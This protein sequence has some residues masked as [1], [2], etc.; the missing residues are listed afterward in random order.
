[1]WTF[2][3]LAIRT[4]VHVSLLSEYTT[5]YQSTYSWRMCTS[6]HVHAVALVDCPFPCRYIGIWKRL[7]GECAVLVS[8]S[9]Y[10][11][12]VYILSLILLI[13]YF[14]YRGYQNVLMESFSPNQVKTTSKRRRKLYSLR[15]VVHRSSMLF[16]KFQNAED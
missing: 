12:C 6:F 11:L 1:M 8:V 3:C 14:S 4:I 2:G 15:R 10:I 7:I 5:S 9:S 16:V 13:T